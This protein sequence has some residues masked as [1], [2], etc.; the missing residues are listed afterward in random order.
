MTFKM[1][2]SLLPF[3]AVTIISLSNCAV[4]KSR[5]RKIGDLRNSLLRENKSVNPAIRG[6]WKS[7]GNGYIL[8]ATSDSVFLYSFTKNFCYKEKNDYIEGLLNSQA[9]FIKRNDT[10]TVY[11]A[12]FGEKSNLLQIKN[13]YVR[14]EE[15]PGNCIG[16]AAMQQ[17]SAKKLFSLFIETL[18]EN[19]AFSKERNMYWAAIQQEFEGKVS[20]STT[21]KELFQIFGEI[22]TLTKDHHTKIITEDGTTMQ[23]RGTPAAEIVSDVFKTQSSVKKLD[24][25]FS[26]FFNTN[27]RNISDSLLNGKGNKAANGQIEWGSLNNNTGY[28]SIYSFS[29]F[30]TNGKSRKQQIDSLNYHME[31]IINTLKDKKAIIVDIS[32]NFGGF[33]AAVLTIASYFTS[34]LKLAYVSQVYNNGTFYNESNVYISPAEKLI[35]Q[36][37]YTF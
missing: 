9:R 22:V 32:F 4:T 27:Y 36:N 7:I 23:F 5:N 29:N 28:I 14:I 6:Y 19:Y 11:P 37:Q 15:L 2:I 10:L 21:G 20:D 1:K 30:T 34:K 33:D 18:Q 13:D 8:E 35:I 25:Y 12:D 3:V 16:F 31:N 26:L 24:D 17:L